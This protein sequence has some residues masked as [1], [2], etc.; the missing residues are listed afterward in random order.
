MDFAIGSAMDFAIGSAMDFAALR[1]NDE[2]RPCE[3]GQR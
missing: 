1:Y 2:N 3:L